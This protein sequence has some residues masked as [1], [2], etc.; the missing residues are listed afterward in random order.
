V[1]AQHRRAHTHA[2]DHRLEAAQELPGLEQRDVGR[3]AA[4]V[5]ADRA[6]EAR[7]RSDRGRADHAA[8]RAREQR[9]RPAKSLRVGE[10][11]RRLHEAQLASGSVARSDAACPRRSGVR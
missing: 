9:V 1:H 10:S 5:E 3:G 7:A 6:R 8:R 4:H 11:A 2:A